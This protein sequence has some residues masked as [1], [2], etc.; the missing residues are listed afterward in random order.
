MS[1]MSSHN[2]VSV[3]GG[4]GSSPGSTTSSIKNLAQTPTYSGSRKSI[5]IGKIEVIYLIY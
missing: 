2:N 5:V 4:G 1:S 3:G